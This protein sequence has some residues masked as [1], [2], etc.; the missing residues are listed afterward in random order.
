MLGHSRDRQGFAASSGDDTRFGKFAGLLEFYPK[1]M[2]LNNSFDGQ[3]IADLLSNES[4]LNWISLE[5]GLPVFQTSR[6]V[7]LLCKIAGYAT[8]KCFLGGIANP[9]CHVA[10]GITIA[11][12]VVDVIHWIEGLFD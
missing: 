5:T 10:V 6:N 8:A 11:C 9:L 2:S 4:F 1:E 7:D 12:F 3:L